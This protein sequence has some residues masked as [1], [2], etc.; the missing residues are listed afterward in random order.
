MLRKILVAVVILAS[1]IFIADP[2]ADI[3]W[4]RDS[5]DNY[6]Y[7]YGGTLFGVEYVK[8]FE[9]PTFPS[10]P[11]LKFTG[12]DVDFLKAIIRNE[13]NFRVHATSSTGALGIAQI[14]RS[15]AKW[16]KVSN[17]YNPISSSFAMCKYLNYLSRKFKS[18]TEILWAYHDGEGAVKKRGPSVAARNYAKTVMHFYE[19]Y[20]KKKK[21]DWFK[22]R[23]LLKVRFDYLPLFSYD[24][25]FGGT[26]SLLGVIDLSGGYILSDIQ[27]GPFIK[28][29]IRI[30][31]DLAF[32]FD[33]EDS[34]KYFGVSFWDINRGIEVL[35][36]SGYGKAKLQVGNFGMDLMRGRISVF[37]RKG[38]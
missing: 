1:L 32:V 9:V 11:F 35:V 13:S 30:F 29:Y 17:P 33:M 28:S 8:V 2:L 16:L 3:I 25:R 10:D 22:D 31:H 18:K 26:F 20:R 19:E 15:T 23:V 12:C 27:N 37:Y 4:M 36:G 7:F 38:F 24:L 21:W 5:K 14:V 34:K 6:L